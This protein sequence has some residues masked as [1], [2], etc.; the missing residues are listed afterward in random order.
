MGVAFYFH[1]YVVDNAVDAINGR[2]EGADD[3]V[4]DWRTLLHP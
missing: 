3:V 2:D 4:Q 1:D